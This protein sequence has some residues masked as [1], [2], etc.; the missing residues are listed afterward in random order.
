MDTTRRYRLILQLWLMTH[1]WL[2]AFGRLQE[3][4]FESNGEDGFSVS[5]SLCGKVCK[6][7]LQRQMTRTTDGRVLYPKRLVFALPLWWHVPYVR[8]MTGSRMD[9]V[10]VF[11]D[12]FRRYTR[13]CGVL[14]CIDCHALLY[15]SSVNRVAVFSTVIEWCFTQNSTSFKVLQRRHV[16]LMIWVV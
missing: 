14:W 5:A 3:A 1:P 9:P 10:P 12:I 6:L 7:K 16:H 4:G 2:C 15:L 11:C 13:C 8:G